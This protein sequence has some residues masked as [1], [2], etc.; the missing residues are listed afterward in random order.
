M[1]IPVIPVERDRNG[2]EISN[3]QI[4]LTFP[5]HKKRL[6]KRIKSESERTGMPQTKIIHTA[7]EEYF[8]RRDELKQLQQSII[9][10]SL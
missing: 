6:R 8:A 9:G 10:A 7:T 3:E 2:S 1:F 4:N 5:Q